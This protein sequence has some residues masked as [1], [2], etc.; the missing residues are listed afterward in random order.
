MGSGTGTV[1]Q[2]DELGYLPVHYRKIENEDQRIGQ[3]PFVV[4][5]VDVCGEDDVVVVLPLMDH[6]HDQ[7]L[8]DDVAGCP[9]F[10]FAFAPIILKLIV[11]E[12]IVGKCGNQPGE[13][14][15]VGRLN[16]CSDRFRQGNSSRGI[17]WKKHDEPPATAP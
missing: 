7:P 6:L 8:A 1:T 14:P 2:D 11:D 9:N 15:T 17:I 13:V 5:S 16:K 10:D 12:G 3:A 4:V